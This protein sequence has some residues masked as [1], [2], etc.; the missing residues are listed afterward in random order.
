M[1]ITKLKVNVQ[2]W[3]TT[4][5]KAE[6]KLFLRQKLSQWKKGS[7]VYCEIFSQQLVCMH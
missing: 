5:I 7:I 6:I 3:L 1:N 4:V 2:V